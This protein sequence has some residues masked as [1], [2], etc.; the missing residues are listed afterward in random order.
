MAGNGLVVRI[1][2]KC[3]DLDTVV[4]YRLS[5]EEWQNE[6]QDMVARGAQGTGQEIR[7]VTDFL[8]KNLGKRAGAQN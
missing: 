6:V 8:I 7:A 3:N 5:A 1:C 4:S 2:T